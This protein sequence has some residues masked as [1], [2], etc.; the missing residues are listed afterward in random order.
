MKLAT[1]TLAAML[2]ATAVTVPQVDD[3]PGYCAGLNRWHAQHPDAVVFDGWPAY[4][5]EQYPTTVATTT[6]PSTTEA[7]TV[8]PAV[9]A[10]ASPRF[11][12]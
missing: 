5:A 6:A 3:E 12:G 10:P 2:T 1:L 4:C 8:A 9:S 11:T 7:P